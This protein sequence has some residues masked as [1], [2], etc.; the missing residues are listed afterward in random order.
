MTV[1]PVISITTEKEDIP[2]DSHPFLGF[3][4]SMKQNKMDRQKTGKFP[5]S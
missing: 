3:P 5:I 1:S 2:T 4:V